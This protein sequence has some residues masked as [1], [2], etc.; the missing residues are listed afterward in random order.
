MSIVASV[1]IP[2][3]NEDRHIGNCLR[4]LLA[5][6]YDPANFE[7]IVVDGES[8]DR[9]VEVVAAIAASSAVPIRVLPNPKRIAPTGMNIGIR[10]ARGRY[11]I[12][13]DAHSEYPPQY[14]RACIE[15]LERTGAANVGGTFETLPGAQT[16][17]AKGI[18]LMTKHPVGVGNAA[19]RLGAKDCYVDTV[20][21]G[22]YR[23]ELFDSIGMFRE[24]LVR[25]QDYELNARI[26]KAGGRIF[27]S[28]RIWVNY[29]N[30]ATFRLF[31]RQAYMNGVH[32]PLAWSRYPESFCWRHS[33][34]LLFVLGL[35]GGGALGFA[36]PLIHLLLL[37]GVGVYAAVVLAAAAQIASRNGWVYLALIPVLMAS[38]HVVYGAT[39]IWGAIRLLLTPRTQGS[40]LMDSALTPTLRS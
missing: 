7:I 3:R 35:M 14:V 23:R 19:F 18:A 20:P 13:V 4:S 34:P 15:E 36:F 9:S 32:M 25:H 38:Y 10:E 40:K 5:N 16:L 29:Y 30:V 17:I 27:L 11:I 12:R 28:S 6:D 37:I 22:A 1:I 26:R 31:M 8:S 21:Y 39:T 2:M 33:A 24:D